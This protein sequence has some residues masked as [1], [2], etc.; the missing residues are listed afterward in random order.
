MLFVKKKNKNLDLRWKNIR[1][2]CHIF[3]FI[4]DFFRIRIEEP[5]YGTDRKYFYIHTF[6][7]SDYFIVFL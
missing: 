7:I 1:F 5:D 2:I 3:N 6:S 4:N